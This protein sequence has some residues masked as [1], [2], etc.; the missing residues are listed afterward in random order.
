[1]KIDWISK[2]DESG[3][4]SKKKK[5]LIREIAIIKPFI[6]LWVNSDASW[7][8]FV[9]DIVVVEGNS[10]SL[11]LAKKACC[12]AVKTWVKHFNESIKDI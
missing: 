7:C 1:M 4:C 8:V 5:T 11:D 3:W 6:E 12:I 10:E 2:F 9:A